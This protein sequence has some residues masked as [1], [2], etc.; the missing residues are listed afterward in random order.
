MK[1]RRPNSHLSAP[2][3]QPEPISDEDLI[4]SFLLALGSSGK[5]EKTLTIYGESVKMLSNFARAEGMP[6]LA[7]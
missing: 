5:R 2:N 1:N 6:C 7:I 4:R 3:V